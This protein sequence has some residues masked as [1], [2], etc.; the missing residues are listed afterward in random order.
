MR[1]YSVTQNHVINTD[2]WISFTRNATNLIIANL[3]SVATAIFKNSFLLGL[4]RLL[5]SLIE[6]FVNCQLG[7]T[8]C[9]TWSMVLRDGGLRRQTQVTAFEGLCPTRNLH[10]SGQ[11]HLGSTQTWE[12]WGECSLLGKTSWVPPTGV[13]ILVLPIFCLWTLVSSLVKGW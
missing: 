10:S 2:I 9:F 5:T 11:H 4:G 8:N 13:K 7:P 1:Q 3:I 6:S 12:C